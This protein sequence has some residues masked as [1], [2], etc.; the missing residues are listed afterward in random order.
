MNHFENVKLNY[1]ATLTNSGQLIFGAM[2]QRPGTSIKLCTLA[3]DI[4][5]DR[6]RI[7]NAQ[8]SRQQSLLISPKGKKSDAIHGL[9]P[10]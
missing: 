1:V 4:N 10:E 9:D 5:D 8:F 7:S 3:V 2:E 6:G